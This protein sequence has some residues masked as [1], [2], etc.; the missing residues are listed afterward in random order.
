M[1]LTSANERD[2]NSL[3]AI[4]RQNREP[5]HVASPT[6]PGGYQRTYDRAAAISD[7]QASGGFREQS[8]YVLQLVGGARVSA[9]SLMPKL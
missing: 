1:L 2:A 5:I 9:A 3:A 4:V 7:E 6:V 8:L